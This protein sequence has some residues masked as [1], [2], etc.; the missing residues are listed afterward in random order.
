MKKTTSREKPIR[1]RFVYIL[2]FIIAVSIGYYVW[3][4]R[5]GGLPV[6]MKW[7]AV[8]R[9]YLV[10]N[11][12]VIQQLLPPW[13]YALLGSLVMNLLFIDLWKTS[14][15]RWKRHERKIMDQRREDRNL[16]D[17]LDSL[18][19][20]NQEL[21]RRQHSDQKKEELPDN[22]TSSPVQKE[23]NGRK[24]I[25]LPNPLV[26]LAENIQKP[27]ASGTQ[28]GESQTPL[29]EE[30]NTQ[31]TGSAANI[32]ST[33]NLV[34]AYLGYLLTQIQASF[35]QQSMN[36]LKDLLNRTNECLTDAD[37]EKLASQV[38]QL[39]AQIGKVKKGTNH[40]RHC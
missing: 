12:I 10:K 2:L 1:S 23:V 27:G 28:Q 16:G 11:G 24:M 39:Q 5:F 25:E 40:C 34:G 7:W 37:Q 38:T 4:V 17:E 20:A 29:Q 18:R 26:S 8:A 15:R 22:A 14:S 31:N 19:I 6:V 36:E 21:Q 35:E 30:K 33:E 9:I 3:T 32:D 13:E